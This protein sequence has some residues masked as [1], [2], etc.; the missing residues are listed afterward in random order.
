MLVSA[1]RVSIVFTPFCIQVVRTFVALDRRASAGT[2]GIPDRSPEPG[3]FGPLHLGN[4]RLELGLRL[5][6][7]Q[8]E[9]VEAGLVQGGNSD[10]LAVDWGR[11]MARCLRLQR[12]L[13]PLQ[14][15]AGCLLLSF[16]ASTPFEF[17]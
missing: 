14:P 12:A 6:R 17:P 11:P 4:R 3:T 2:V 15:C 9:G 8:S 10:L 1:L 7:I 5:A 16:V 13:S